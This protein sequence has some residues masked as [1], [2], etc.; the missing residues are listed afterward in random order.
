MAC[1]S[2][3]LPM[4]PDGSQWFSMAQ[5]PARWPAQVLAPVTSSGTSLATSSMNSSGSSSDTSSVTRAQV[6]ASVTNSGTSSA[7]SSV[8]SST[9][10]SMVNSVTSSGTSSATNSATSSTTSLGDRWPGD[11]LIGP[12]G[13]ARLIIGLAVFVTRATESVVQKVEVCKKWKITNSPFFTE[14]KSSRSEQVHCW[15]SWCRFASRVDWCRAI[16][17]ADWARHSVNGRALRT[18]SEKLARSV[19]S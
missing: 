16:T 17:R 7:T 8:T 6:L 9:I 5:W 3:W 2:Q 1:G 15:C 10:S 18:I 4:T 13:R 11:Q 14:R 19:K 12:I